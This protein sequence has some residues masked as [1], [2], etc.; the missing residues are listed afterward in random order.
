NIADG[1]A[2]DAMRAFL[3]T[4][5]MDGTVV[6]GEG[7]KDQAPMLYNGEKVGDGLGPKVDVAVDPI[8]GTSLT[9]M[10][11]N[12]ALS[13][14]AVAERGSMNDASTAFYMDKMYVGPEASARVD[15]RLPVTQNFQLL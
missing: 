15:L 10:G 1:A 2:V 7:E 3:H 6:I 4:V 9:A 8:D 13:V 14:M 11:Y 5:H 12:N